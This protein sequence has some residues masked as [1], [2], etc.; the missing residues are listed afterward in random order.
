M[1]NKKPTTPTEIM[2][3]FESVLDIFLSDIRHRERA[4]F[5]LCDN[6][7]EM[8]CKT[9]AKQKNHLFDTHCDFYRAWNAPGVKLPKNGLGGRVHGRRDTRNTMQHASAAVTVDIQSCADAILD[10]PDVITKLWGHD[11]LNNLRPWQQVSIRV[12]RLYSTTGDATIRRQFEDQM[13]IERWRGNAEERPPRVNETIIE[14]GLRNHW[15]IAVKQNP[16]QVE[17]IL[18][19]LGVN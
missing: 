4:A 11:A 13:R 19:N 15:A 14:C 3:A 18:N 2:D 7:V 12:V 1:T 10:L 16:H 9:K 6:L 8:A 5:I 17:Q